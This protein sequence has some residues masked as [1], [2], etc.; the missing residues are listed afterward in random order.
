[1]DGL[2]HLGITATR[3]LETIRFYN[4]LLRLPY[5]SS[6][7]NFGK[8]HDMM[9][10]LKGAVNLLHWFQLKDQGIEFFHLPTHK[11]ERRA[12]RELSEPG[13]SFFSLW[14][15]GFDV[16]LERFRRRGLDCRVVDEGQCRAAL[17]REPDG[18]PVALFEKPGGGDTPKVDAIGETGLTVTDF[19]GY[20]EYFDALGFSEEKDGGGGY[21][22][23][24]F[25]LREPV[26]TK[27]Y[28]D[29]R[30]LCFPKSG[31]EKIPHGFP[32]SPSEPR[33]CFADPGV[34]H[35]CWYTADIGEFHERAR[36][37]GVSFQFAPVAIPGGARM[38]YFQDPE[39]NTLECME[40]PAAM[41]G[42]ADLIGG[43]RRAQMELFDRLT[44]TADILSLGR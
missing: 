33:G 5:I 7:L 13:W 26:L 9:Y 6:S 1:M 22:E 36:S 31:R 4:G 17:V 18:V 43:A 38:A 44:A 35:V 39:G 28:G 12:P 40:V 16:Y 30:L 19:D 3:P 20:D 10:R 15:E 25:E 24:L 37:A 34:K 29:V 32:R 23:E 8:K 42:A 2:Q 21:V 14:V 11:P 27:R 41:R